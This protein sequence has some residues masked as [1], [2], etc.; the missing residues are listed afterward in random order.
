M[1]VAFILLS[2]ELIIISLADKNKKKW[3]GNVIYLDG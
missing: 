2:C 1:E 3:N